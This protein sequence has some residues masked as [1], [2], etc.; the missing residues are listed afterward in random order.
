VTPERKPKSD[1]EIERLRHLSFFR[2][3]TPDELRFLLSRGQDR[4]LASHELVATEGTRKQR[5]VLYVVLKGTLEYVRRVR[6][7]RPAVLFRLSPGDVGGFLTFFTDEPSPVSVRST[8][9]SLVFEI[10]RREFQGLMEEWPALAAKVLFALLG[11]T[12]RH[13]KGVLEGQVT[14]AAWMLEVAHQLRQLPLIRDD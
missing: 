7:E 1:R 11:A 3:F 4:R 2:D 10:G 8:G 13:L 14:V 5:R 6:G 9:P 12:V